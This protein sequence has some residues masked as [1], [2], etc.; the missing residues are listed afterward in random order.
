MPFLPWKLLKSRRFWLTVSLVSLFWMVYFSPWKLQ[1]IDPVSLTNS[2]EK[3]G[4]WAI[5]GYILLY[6]L[7][8]IVGIPAIP[9]TMA[10][11]IFF[12]LGWGTFWSVIAATL[13][14]IA[15]FVMTRYLL[16]NWALKTFSRHYAIRK[17]NRATTQNPL[18]FVL[19]VRLAPIFPFNLCNFLFGLTPIQLQD[20]SLGTVLGIIPGTFTYTWLGVSGKR[21]IEGSDRFSIFLA[22]AIATLLCLLPSITR[23]RLHWN[24]ETE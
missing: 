7:L 12:G 14:A 11:G 9:L 3:W 5:F 24:E 1:N 10:G 8:T 23:K 17:F 21:A 18:K 13:G 6:I 15:A 20:Y 2:I 4:N 16:Q 19:F 22:L